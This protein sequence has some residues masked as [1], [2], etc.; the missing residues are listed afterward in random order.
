ME[1]LHRHA[2]EPS[3]VAGDA[4]GKLMTRARDLYVEAVDAAGLSHTKK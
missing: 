2:I 4:L 3:G 1:Q